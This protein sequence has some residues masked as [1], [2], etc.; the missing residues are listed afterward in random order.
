L[1]FSEHIA[2]AV[3]NPNAH[4][5]AAADAVAHGFLQC[6]F[7]RV[8][9]ETGF[10]TELN[11]LKRRLNR[12]FRP[13]VDGGLAAPKCRTGSGSVSEGCPLR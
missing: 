7:E 11:R 9:A 13:P 2:H 10:R 12:P 3:P 1:A 8:E 4:R 5:S 6:R